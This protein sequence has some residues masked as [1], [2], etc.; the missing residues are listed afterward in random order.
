MDTLQEQFNLLS[1]FRFYFNSNKTL[2][3]RN[4]EYEL[5]HERKVIVEKIQVAW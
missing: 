3:D 2:P 1:F 5:I 4:A